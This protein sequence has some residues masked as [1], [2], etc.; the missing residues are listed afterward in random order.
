MAGYS[1]AGT[2][3]ASGVLDGGGDI[4]VD[5]TS[6]AELYPGGMTVE[7]RVTVINHGG[8]SYE[9]AGLTPVLQATTPGCPAAFVSAEPPSVMPVVPPGASVVVTM[10]VT[11]STAAPVACQGGA[12]DVAVTVQGRS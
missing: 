5:A 9:V 7:L 2:G 10:P 4:T 8:D 1:A 12:F 6:E 3:Q 11:L